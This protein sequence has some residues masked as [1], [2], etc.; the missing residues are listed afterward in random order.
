MLKTKLS[1]LTNR[2][3]YTVQYTSNKCKNEIVEAWLVDNRMR[4]IVWSIWSISRIF[5][6][7]AISRLCLFVISS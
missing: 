4:P 7:A 1:S 5:Y 6:T 2:R 3:L